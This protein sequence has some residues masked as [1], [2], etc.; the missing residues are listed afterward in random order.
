MTHTNVSAFRPGVHAMLTHLFGELEI[1]PDRW[2]TAH[3]RLLSALATPVERPGGWDLVIRI[4]P[5]VPDVPSLSGWAVRLEE[6]DLSAEIDDGGRLRLSGVD[7]TRPCRLYVYKPRW[8]LPEPIRQ[9]VSQ[10][11]AAAAAAWNEF[12]RRANA[13]SPAQLA[14][15]GGDLE[16][17]RPGSRAPR[18]TDLRKLIGWKSSDR[19]FALDVA[20]SPAGS[21][22]MWLRSTDRELDGV[23]LL[24][25][26]GDTRRRATFDVV[27]AGAE[28][29]VIL[30]CTAATSGV[31]FQLL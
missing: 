13:P 14:A 5:N 31:E 20:V 28:A 18:A 19:L 15:M 8:M 4:Q 17:A 27:G 3:T 2:T 23:P 11:L 29:E 10:D 26:A 7:L 6:T 12:L 24:V 30:D 9:R 22:P 16:D 21:V 25:R 1:D